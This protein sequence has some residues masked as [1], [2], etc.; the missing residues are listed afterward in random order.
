VLSLVPAAVG[1]ATTFVLTAG[2]VRAQALTPS[3]GAV[4][5]VFGSVIVVV[6]GFPFLA[7][8]ILFVVGSVLA[9]RYRM[10]E[11]RR[12]NVQEG[13]HGERGVSNVVAHIVIPTALAV[14]ALGS[15]P[16]LPLSTL[17][18]LYAS[19][20]A[21]GASDTF[22]SEF[23]VL[24]GRARSILSYRP[25]E[26]GTNGGISGMGEVFAL[27][28]S[29]TTALAAFG[30]FLLFGP[31]LPG[32]ALFLLT[33]TGAGFVGC[34]IDSVLGATLENSGHLTKHSTNFLGMLASV[35]IAAAVLVAAGGSI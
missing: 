23:G 14:T 27:V 21:F 12:R 8:L 17:A 9:T 19:A 5:G 22:A 4:A 20:L 33:A 15:P 3:G 24:A 16:L 26:P 10:D 31:G 30:L 2:A 35:A 6:A 7:L 29:A 25:V 13:N 18:L 34:Q 32:T 1:V 28:G 11:K